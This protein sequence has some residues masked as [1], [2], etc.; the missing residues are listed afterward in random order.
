MTMGDKM[1][2]M[3]GGVLQQV[4]SP[5]RLFHSPRNLFVA[6]FMG[7]PEMNLFHATV[8]GEAGERT[9]RIGTQELAV[10]PGLQNEP[11]LAGGGTVA[12]GIRP[13]HLHDAAFAGELPPGRILRGEVVVTEVLGSEVLLHVELEAEA[14]TFREA[15]G[16]TA[17]D[18]AVPVSS[19]RARMV[20]RLDARTRPEAGEVVQLCLDPAELHFFDLETRLAIEARR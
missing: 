6:S 3:N 10:P 4:D 8:Q 15:G 7:S 1:A 19:G 9:V 16:P 12:V 18:E 2:V 13:E 5:E 20:A 14:V 17:D 11:A